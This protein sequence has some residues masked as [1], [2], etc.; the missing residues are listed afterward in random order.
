MRKCGHSAFLF[1]RKLLR[2]PSREVLRHT[3]A[4]CTQSFSV[5]SATLDI[6]TTYWSLLIQT[7]WEPNHIWRAS[8]FPSQTV[9]RI[10]SSSHLP[11]R[12]IL[13]CLLSLP[14]LMTG[15]KRL[16]LTIS[17]GTNLQ[18]MLSV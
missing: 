5:N 8:N 1:I 4:L 12:L 6:I 2:K 7:V 16:F 17:S 10:A 18:H 13:L 14:S 15:A 11:N 3:N 9:R